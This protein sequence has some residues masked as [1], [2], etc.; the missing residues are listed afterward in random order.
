MIAC[1]QPCKPPSNA[2]SSNPSLIFPSS[3][4]EMVNQ[5]AADLNLKGGKAKGK[6]PRTLL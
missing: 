3:S 5:R 6:I 2:S 1:S 4:S